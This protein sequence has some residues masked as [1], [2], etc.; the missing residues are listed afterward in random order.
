[1]P[2]SIFT[3][4]GGP[5]VAVGWAQQALRQIGAPVTPGNVQF[6]YDWEKS[7]GGGGK[8]NPLNM[9]PV[10]GQPTLTTTGQQFGG[11]AADYASW[12]AGL[13]GFNA[14]MNMSNYTAVRDALI[15][16]KPQAARA[17]LIASPWASSHY[18][19]GTK[20]NNDPVPGGS[21]ILP[22][23]TSSTQAAAQGSQDQ[24]L[25]SIPN[26]DPASSLPLVGSFF[27]STA[28]CVISKTQ[29]RA[30]LGTLVLLAGSTV[31]LI[32]AVVMV[33][34]GF[35]KTGGLNAASN[36]A[37]KVPGGQGVA[38]GLQAA[39]SRLNRT[40]RQAAAS[41]RAAAR[42]NTASSQTGGAPAASPAAS[43]P[44]PRGRRR[45]PIRP[46]TQGP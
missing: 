7:E 25:F 1:M 21:P 6:M 31:L 42:K 5:E 24:C 20:W 3:D 32:G 12:Q 15:A 8:Y 45:Y 34:W 4:G 27:P 22:P 11:G 30:I 41:R 14:Y 37:A 13:Q 18:G 40:G 38:A 16:N 26:V 19:W 2:W 10:P 33:A 28:A 44:P 36:V 23:A 43:P 46:S 9:G 35:Q 29:G 39:D 17:A